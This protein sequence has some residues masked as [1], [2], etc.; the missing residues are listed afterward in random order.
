M[1]SFQLIW[2]I[3]AVMLPRPLDSLIRG[4]WHRHQLS[5]LSANGGG[6]EV[7]LNDL[8]F[9]SGG[10]LKLE[11]ELVAEEAAKEAAQMKDKAL[12]GSPGSSRRRL[13]TPAE[14]AK[15]E[16][17]QQQPQQQPQEM[18]AAEAVPPGRQASSSSSSSSSSSNSTAKPRLPFLDV[19]SIG[20]TG[21][22]VERSGNFIL[23]PVRPAS[24][25]GEGAAPPAPAGVIHFL[26]GAFVGAA[27]HLT[28]RYLLESLSEAGY[29]VVATPYRLD[30]DYVRSCDSI[31]SKFDS[32]AVELAAEYGPVPVIGLGHS[33][34]ALLQVLITSLFPDAPRAANVLI[35]FNNRPAQQSIPGLE[36]FIGPFS[37]LIMTEG[38]QGTSIRSSLSG[39]RSAVEK[40]L[41]LYADSQLSPAFVG[42]EVLPILRQGIEIVDQIPPLLNDIATGV[43]EFLPS[44]VDTKEVCRRMYR[45]VCD[46]GRFIWGI[47]FSLCYGGMHGQY[48][49][50]PH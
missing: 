35:S 40:S 32:V 43:R 7:V 23:H 39:L 44:P 37:E 24:A 5:L 49:Q 21:R 10:L 28:Y 47:L 11:Q 36:E 33:C 41:K 1:Q 17:S 30:F 13:P 8:F 48:R 2:A 22:W 15:V 14:V 38:E 3:L 9:H 45:G 27:P 4:G 18:R 29:V 34:G 26:G 20:L 25:N 42:K 31:L 16:Q 50:L 12:L 19:E 46:V 6:R